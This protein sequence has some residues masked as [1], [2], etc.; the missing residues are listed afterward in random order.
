MFAFASRV[1]G[2][3]R[4]TAATVQQGAQGITVIGGI[5]QTTLRGHIGHKFSPDRGIPAMAGADDQPPGAA[6]LIDC[7]MDFGGPSPA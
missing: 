1:V 6:V 2:D 4:L 5:G 3:D 7:G